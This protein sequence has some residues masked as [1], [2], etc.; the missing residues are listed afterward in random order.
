[1][2]NTYAKYKSP[3]TVSTFYRFKIGRIGKGRKV[4]YIQH[5]ECADGTVKHIPHFTAKIKKY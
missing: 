1:M 4:A 5:I 3:K 2:P